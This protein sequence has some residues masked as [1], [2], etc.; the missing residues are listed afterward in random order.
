[1]KRV[2]LIIGII[3]IVLIALVLIGAIVL[4]LFFL[5]MTPKPSEKRVAGIFKNERQEFE[6]I[7][8]AFIGIDADVLYINNTRNDYNQIEV[9]DKVP[10]ETYE[11]N[12]EEL[13]N[14]ITFLFD[15]RYCDSIDK[16]RNY[17][18]F[19]MWGTLDASS[20]IAYSIDGELPDICG[21]MPDNR[22]ILELVPLENDGWYYY[23]LKIV[24][25]TSSV[26]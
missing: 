8:D 25:A 15:N 2:L 18:S 4:S 22:K 1:M 9:L 13:H 10:V 14:A 11:Y 23:Y 26:P 17:V 3:G 5:P 16:E 12:D 7:A 20:G 6:L 19:S 21:Q 24:K